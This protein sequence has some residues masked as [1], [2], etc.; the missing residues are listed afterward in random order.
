[1]STAE[2]MQQLAASIDQDADDYNQL[3][4]TLEAE[5]AATVLLRNAH[6]A[7][8]RQIKA[9]NDQIAELMLQAEQM[10]TVVKRVDAASEMV[11]QYKAQKDAAERKLAEERSRHKVQ[12]ADLQGGNPKDKA[13]IK[14]LKSEKADQ[15]VVIEALRK[16]NAELKRTAADLMQQKKTA[17]AY[18]AQLTFTTV[19][20]NEKELLMYFPKKI[21]S[22]VEGELVDVC[23]SLLWL[24]RRT[25]RGGLVTLDHDDM[26]CMGKAPAGGLKVS[27]DV[28]DFAGAWLRKV[29]R[30]GNIVTAEDFLAL[31]TGND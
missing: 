25:G 22:K 29:K 15:L 6:Q 7:D 14:R 27:K 8:Q 17:E 18:A 5:R 21:I 24:D 11:T 1:M 3:V 28:E 13:L 2:I 12:L 20:S 10:A 30:Q 4:E 9:L 26:P 16:Q 31:S 19:Y 23:Q